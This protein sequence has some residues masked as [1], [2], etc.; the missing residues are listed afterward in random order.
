MDDRDLILGGLSKASCLVMQERPTKYMD[1]I[2]PERFIQ[3]QTEE[4]AIQKLV[5]AKRRKQKRATA[6]KRRP[7]AKWTN[8]DFVSFFR[9]ALST[10]SVF[11]GPTS[12]T[13]SQVVGRIHDDL[14]DKYKDE[15]SPLVL[16]DFFEW[17]SAVFGPKMEGKE[18]H[19]SY[20]GSEN[21]IDRFLKGYVEKPTVP[22]RPLPETPNLD[23]LEP[24][25]S[26]GEIYGIG[27]LP[28]LLL[29][30]GIVEAHDYLL[31]CSKERPDK[32]IQNALSD[33][34]KEALEDV[35]QQ[36]IERSPYARNI[37]PFDFV[38]ACKPL[39]ELLGI[40]RLDGVDYKRFFKSS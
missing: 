12:I 35:I 27:G 33:F 25:K 32:S 23:E 34:T 17:C 1:E 4:D 10:H 36:T 2:E 15:M 16:R 7:I 39:M 37:T 3:K 30:R 40:H 29:E 11:V 13:A 31:K 24:A 5:K 6:Y 20:F 9:E 14:V 28:M 19:I 38:R 8:S 21:I 18:V 22:K 26:P